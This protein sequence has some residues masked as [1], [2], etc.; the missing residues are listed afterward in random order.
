VIIPAYDESAGI[1]RCLDAL[2]SGIDPG[3]LDVI[4]VCNG[5]RDHTAALARGSGHPVR[6]I[7]LPTASKPAALRAGDQAARALPRLYLDADVILDG[8]A[9]CAVLDRLR[10]GALAAR[11][12]VRYDSSHSTWPVRS[13]YRARARTPALLDSLWGAGV[14]G[15]SEQGRSRFAA[16][17]D[18]VADDLWVDRH[19]AADEI[20]IVDVAPVVVRVPRRSR[21]L[22]RILRRTYRGK[23]ENAALD[24]HR[25]GR[26]TTASVVR[27]LPRYAVAGPSATLDAATYAAF[28]AAAR[29]AVALHRAVTWDRDESSRAGA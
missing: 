22:V 24:P 19:F 26:S 18:L 29:I 17:P 4:V 23:R 27:Q 11:P 9:A 16:F 10:A 2:F 8:G 15:L 6:V 14:Y 20:T 1:R 28:A 7:E 3:Q 13:Y 21:D 25:K 5:C 12:A